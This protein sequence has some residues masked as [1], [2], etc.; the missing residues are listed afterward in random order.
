M[1]NLK[2]DFKI[3]IQPW[4]CLGFVVACALMCGGAAYFL[5]YIP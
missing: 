1:S 4:G 3:T 2:L 5:G